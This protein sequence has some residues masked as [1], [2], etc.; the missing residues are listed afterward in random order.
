MKKQT[1]NILMY[2]AL[3]IAILIALNIIILLTSYKSPQ[4][5]INKEE[6][7]E[8]KFL[9][10]NDTTLVSINIPAIDL[11]GKGVSTILTIEAV[12]GTGRT[13]VDIESLLFWADTQQSI[14]MARFVAGNI[15]KINP[16]E[17]DLVYNIKANASLIGGPSAG[18]ALTLGTIFALEGK[19]PKDN[20]MITGTINHDGTIGPVIG[21]LE[22][23]KASKQAG[24]TLFLVPLMQSREVIYETTKYCQKFGTTE[25]CTTETIPKSI[26][27]EEEAEIKVIEVSS[28]QEALKYFE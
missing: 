18:A 14:R 3:I 19:K 26:N 6:K 10:L 16:D 28:I 2:L 17:Y 21:I 9:K 5:S 11:E 27:I 15:S 1:R 20:V 4:E 7:Q 22:K 13:L 8:N 25:V 23:A 12:K 24:A